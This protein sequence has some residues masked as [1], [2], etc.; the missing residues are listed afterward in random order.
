MHQKKD[1][2]RPKEYRMNLGNIVTIVI[3][4]YNG[5]KFISSA[6]DSVLMQSSQDW[7]LIVVN[8]GSA[9]ATSSIIDSYAAKDPR[10]KVFHQPNGGVNSARAKGVEEAQGEYLL[11]LDADDT[12]ESDAVGYLQDRMTDDI[13]LL[14]EGS[15]DRLIGKEEYISDLWKGRVGPA[16][17]G[18]MFRTSVY[19]QLDY[20]LERRIAMGEDLLL[21]SMFAL[22]V[23]KILILPRKF[24]NVNRNNEASVT[25]TFKHNW[26]YEKYYFSKV[27]ELFLNKCRDWSSYGEI[28]YL[29]NK[30]WLNAMKYT[31]LDGNGINYDDSEFRAARN[32][33]IAGKHKLGPSERMIFYIRNPKLYRFILNTLLKLKR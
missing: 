25:K 27:E 32:Y 1:Q 2:A 14:A 20:T 5:E 30:S 11:F 13:D 29:V 8:D 31:I 26:E 21:N 33:F 23:D 24:Y 22:K 6:I 4:V 3:P 7:E 10:I 12:L 17:W 28:E 15:G 19:R 16:L 9:D 18:K